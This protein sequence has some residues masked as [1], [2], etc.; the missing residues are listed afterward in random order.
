MRRNYGIDLLRMLSM[1]MI[2]IL[3]ILGQ[4]GLLENVQLFSISDYGLHFVEIFCYCAVNCFALTSGYVLYGNRVKISKLMELWL[5]IIFYSVSVLF[6][7]LLFSPSLIHGADILKTFLPITTNAYWYLSAYFGLCIFVPFL[8]IAIEKVDRKTFSLILLSIFILLVFI[9]VFVNTDP[10]IMNEGYSM[11]WLIILYLLGSYIRKYSIAEKITAKKSFLFYFLVNISAFI[12]GLC[13]VNIYYHITGAV[14]GWGFVI[15]Y[16]APTVVLSS[17]FLFL[18]FA[19]VKIPSKLVNYVM[20]LSPACLGVYIIHTNELVFN[21]LLKDIAYP[22]IHYGGFFRILIMVFCLA[23]L[24]YLVCSL[25]DLIRIFIFRICCIKNIC[26]Y[27]ENYIFNKI[28]QLFPNNLA[29]K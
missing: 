29:G 1:L 24:I 17:I 18:F 11:I 10:Y 25:I 7:F 20:L 21:N 15:N 8:N 23:I 2:V 22:M 19:K 12:F 5:E 6:L 27:L 3:H 28:N 9:P 13:I 26:V 16:C 4:G 14:K